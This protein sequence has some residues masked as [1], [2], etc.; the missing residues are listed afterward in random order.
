MTVGDWTA[1]VW[2]DDNL[3]T[4]IMSTKYHPAYL[5]GGCW[6][7]TRPGVFFLTRMDG[8]LDVWD[9]YHSQNDVAYSHKVCERPLSSISVS[10]NSSGAP[11]RLVAT[12]DVDGTVYVLQVCESLAQLQSNEKLAIGGMLDREMKREK[13][14]ESRAKELRRKQAQAKAAQAKAAAGEEE[15]KDEAMDE[16]LRKVDE[17]FIA[18][19]KDD[20]AKP[21]SAAI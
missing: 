20:D 21:E 12:G 2:A 5:T 8:V 4:P 9:F 15:T 19:I 17:D 3:K 18:M 11:G 6:S 13:N 10:P 16:L 7:P 14:L 1:R